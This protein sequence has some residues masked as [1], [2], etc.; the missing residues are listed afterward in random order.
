MLFDALTGRLAAEPIKD[1]THRTGTWGITLITATLAVTPL[2]RAT[3]WNRLQSY[4]RMLG[5]FAFTYLALHF[6]VYLVLDQF[7]DWHT[8]A[9]DIVKRPYITVGFTGLMLMVPLAVTSTRGWVR[10]LGKRWVSLHALLYVTALAGIVHFTWSQ[11]KDITRPTRYA[12]VLVVLLGAR[13]VPKGPFRRGGARGVAA[14][15]PE[16]VRVAAPL[17]P[18]PGTG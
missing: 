18:G 5:L 9:K 8:I 10:R 13:L 11:K 15:P 4:R 12:A 14:A 2:R 16:D 3:G 1:L 7:F 17:V 6:L